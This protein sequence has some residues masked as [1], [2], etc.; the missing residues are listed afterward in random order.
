MEAKVLDFNGKDTGRKVQLSDSV[1]GIEPNNHAVYLDVKQYLLIK[2]RN[3]IAKERAEV[4][5]VIVRLK[6]KELVLVWCSKESIV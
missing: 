4:A 5:E 2:T 6:Q 1:F 3:A